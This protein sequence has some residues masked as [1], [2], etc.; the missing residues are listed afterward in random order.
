MTRADR[1]KSQ[2]AQLNED[3]R[4]AIRHMNHF[5]LAEIGKKLREKEAELAEALDREPKK[6]SQVL[7][8]TEMAREDM[9]R[10]LLKCSLA[11]DYLNNCAEEVKTALKKYNLNDFSFRPDVD[12]LCRLSQKLASLV[13]IPNQTSLTDMICDN[14]EFIDACDNAANEHLKEKLH[15]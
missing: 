7:S 15:L 4:V 11:A 9:Y 13:I 3:R 1:I 14:S 2:I 10:K 5:K 12:E 8:H 6:L